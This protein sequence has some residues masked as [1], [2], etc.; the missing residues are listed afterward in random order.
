[1][2]NELYL[3][4]AEV[5]KMCEGT[6]LEDTP[7]VCVKNP[8]I[9]SFSKHPDFSMPRMGD[10]EFAIAVLKGRPVF[11]GDKVFVKDNKYPY[12]NWRSFECWKDQIKVLSKDWT[13]EEPKKKFKL[14][15]H[16]L[17]CP[18]EVSEFWPLKSLDRSLIIDNYNVFLFDTEEDAKFVKDTLIKIFKEN[19]K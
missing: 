10:S 9:Q 11:I 15:E 14:G 1:M 8:W 2:S 16:L 5:I 13:W 19:L 4:Y 3:K 17:P 18:K 7:W 12:V 6:E